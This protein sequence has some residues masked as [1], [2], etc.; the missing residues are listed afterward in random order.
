MGTVP[1]LRHEWAQVQAMAA[2]VRQHPQAGPLF[3]GQ[4]IAERSL[5]WTDP[6]TGVRCRVR[7]DWL[8]ELP[9]L[10]LAVDLKTTKDASPQAV[11]KAIRDYSYHQ[12]DALYI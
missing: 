5:Y 8:K 7:P 3:T 1:L 11:Q 4:G 6:A 9:G 10:T 12:Q 2:A